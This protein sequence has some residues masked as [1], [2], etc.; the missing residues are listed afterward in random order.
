MGKFIRK[1]V[2][3][4]EQPE[5]TEIKPEAGFCIKTRVANSEK[6]G[7]QKAFINITSHV[8][9]DPPLNAMDKPVAERH[10][11]EKGLESLRVPQ[12]CGHPRADDN[13]K[14]IDVVFHPWVVGRACRGELT[15]YYQ[16]RLLQL[17]IPFV[18]AETGVKLDMSSIKIL[19]NRKY[20]SGGGVD[21]KTPW[22][23][24]V[25]TGDPKPKKSLD[26]NRVDDAYADLLGPEA[27]SR[28]QVGKLNCPGARKGAVKKGFLNSAKMKTEGTGMYDADGSGEGV[29]HEDAG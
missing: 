20:M 21:R 22:P 4:P 19:K 11:D 9:V 25:E 10:L 26:K 13:A 12:F 16:Q 7:G 18:E 17:T 1:M 14:Y 8:M 27:A 29:Q 6:E 23:I 5:I 3:Q 2:A 15:S 24:S 28:M